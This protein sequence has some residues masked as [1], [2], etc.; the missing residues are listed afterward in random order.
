[1]GLLLLQVVSQTAIEYLVLMIYSVFGGAALGVW[2]SS[3]FIPFFQAL[4]EGMLRPP[5]IIPVI[6][7]QDIARI[8]GAFVL[9]LI[10]AQTAVI[11]ST[12]RKGVFQALRLGDQE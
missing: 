4:D 10:I 7:W 6:A 8:C 3:L 9:V 1:M 2:A 5:S 11:A 12:L